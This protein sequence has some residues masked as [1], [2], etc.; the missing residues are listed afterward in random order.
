MPFRK[1]VKS[2]SHHNPEKG[3]MIP[4]IGNPETGSDKTIKRFPQDIHSSVSHSALRLKQSKMK[5]CKWISE[6]VKR[7]KCITTEPQQIGQL[8]CCCMQLGCCRL[9]TDVRHSSNGCD[10]SNRNGFY[11]GRP[12]KD[13]VDC[14]RVQNLVRIN[15][16]VVI[17]SYWYSG[18]KDWKWSPANEF[19]S[20]W[21]GENVSPRN[22]CRSGD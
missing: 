7:W 13:I 10:F 6:P 12:F 18:W 15:Q 20:R 11:V 22:C 9:V 3:R 16:Q 1:L 5:S 14:A 4:K 21:N 8:S 19:R 2:I 17:L